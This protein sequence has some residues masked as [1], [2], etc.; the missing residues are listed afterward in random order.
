M[1]DVPQPGLN[2]RLT[3]PRLG[4]KEEG[5]GGSACPIL[6]QKPKESTL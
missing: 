3:Y 1:S 5:R 6:R 2:N 4:R